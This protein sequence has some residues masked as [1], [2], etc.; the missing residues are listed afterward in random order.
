MKVPF[1][2][3]RPA[4]GA[5]MVKQK[6]SLKKNLLSFS[7]FGLIQTVLLRL[8]TTS[9]LIGLWMLMMHLDIEYL[10]ACGAWAMRGMGQLVLPP[11]IFFVSFFHHLLHRPPVLDT[12]S[13]FATDMPAPRRLGKSFQY[14]Q[15]S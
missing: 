14:H 15:E 3:L 9:L 6:L 2:A 10:P 8:Y 1:G 5:V 11:T 12:K 4:R 13:G 7:H